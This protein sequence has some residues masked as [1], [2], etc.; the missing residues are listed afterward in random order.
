[1]TYQEHLETITRIGREYRYCKSL[2]SLFELDQ[3]TMLP[4]QGGDYRQETAAW[5]AE[6]KNGL[7]LTEEAAREEAYF[8]GVDLNQM[9]DPVERGIIRTFLSRRRVA[10]R[11]PED[12]QRQYSLLKARCMQKWKEAREARDY[13]IFMPWLKQAFD[14]K[15][16]IARAINPDAPAFATLVSLTDDGAD[17]AEISRQF[18]VLKHG[19]KALLDK[20]A[21]GKAPETVDYPTAD[22]AAMSAFAQRMA[23]ELGFSPEVGSF[24]DKVIHGFTSFM[25]PRDARIST[26]RNGSHELIFTCLHEAGHA[27]Y[28]TGSSQRLIDAGLWGGIEGGFHEAISRFYENMVG[29]SRAYWEYCFPKLAA[30]IP[31]YAHMDPDRF[32]LGLHRVHPTCK[33]IASDEVTYSL[34]AILRFELERDYFAGKLSAEEMADAWNQKYQDYLGLCP[35]DDTQG[36]LQDMHWAG[37]YIGYFQSYALGNIYDGQ[38]LQALERD[39]PRWQEDIRQGNFEPLRQWM[40]E[41][42]WQWGCCFTAG[43]LIRRVTGNPLDARPFLDYLDRKYSPI[44]GLEPGLAAK[45]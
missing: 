30:A 35:P 42:I 22:P 10:A 34:H 5:V 37:D 1:M 16:Q 8:D 20:L 40:T 36:V 18:D 17:V 4:A 44:Y 33:R 41:H 31:E 27:M 7:Y 14:L 24:N 19:L 38:I 6:K 26:Y 39:M 45:A 15:G 3:W 11:T 32:Y 2:E 23:R 12:L 25:G 28:S 43:E 13:K 29:R 9:E 21:G